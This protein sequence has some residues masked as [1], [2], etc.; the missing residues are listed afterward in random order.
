MKAKSFMIIAGETSGDMVA[1]ELV[2]A[3]RAETME[4]R[5]PMTWDYQPLETSLAPRF[6]GAGGAHLAEAGV[7][8]AVDMTAHSVTGISEVLKKYAEFRRLFKL[9]YRL[10]LQREPD[11]IICVDFSGFNRRFAHAIKHYTRSRSDWFHDWRPKI[12]QY[13]SPQVWASRANRVYQMAQDFDLLLSI[14]AFERAWY[15]E[16][17]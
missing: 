6:F 2:E 13:V 11:V 10:A 3:I 15:A 14:V 7:E 5:A 12:I 9:L 8:L 1:A 4:E 16:R 17:V